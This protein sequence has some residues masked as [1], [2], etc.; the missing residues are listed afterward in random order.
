MVSALSIGVS[1]ALFADL[2]MLS[3]PLAFL[4]GSEGR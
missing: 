4:A 2:V 3:P 1:H